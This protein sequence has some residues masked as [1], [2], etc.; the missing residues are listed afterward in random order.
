MSDVSL[1]RWDQT[2]SPQRN[3]PTRANVLL[4]FCFF[5][6]KK[7]KKD[8]LIFLS[9]KNSGVLLLKC[10]HQKSS[11]LVINYGSDVQKDR[12]FNEFPP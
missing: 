9:V 1:L 10:C 4:D 8:M 6:Q 7:K 11:I 12:I 5:N 2:D 3:A